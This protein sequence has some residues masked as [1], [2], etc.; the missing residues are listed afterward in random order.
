M[1]DNSLSVRWIGNVATV[2]DNFE[3]IKY[4]S[5]LKQP[6]LTDKIV[7]VVKIN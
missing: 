5:I 6:F 3:W 4:N 2:N 7:T 1:L